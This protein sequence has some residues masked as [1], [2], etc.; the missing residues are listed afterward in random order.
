MKAAELRRQLDALR[1]EIRSPSE[2]PE[3]TEE[4]ETRL[5]AALDEF[6]PL[7]QRTV[8]AERRAAQVERIRLEATRSAE[9]W[10]GQSPQQMR[11]VDPFAGDVRSAP[12]GELRDR[13]LAAVDQRGRHLNNR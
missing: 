13:A 1:E 3:P 7:E 12:R 4:Q 2:L 11:R 10:D 9:G 5:A 8:A 6:T